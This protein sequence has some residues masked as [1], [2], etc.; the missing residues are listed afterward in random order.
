MLAQGLVNNPEQFQTQMCPVILRGGT[1]GDPGC[2]HAHH[3]TELRAGKSAKLG[4]IPRDW[5]TQFCESDKGVAYL[6]FICGMAM[7]LCACSNQQTVSL[8]EGRRSEVAN[9]LTY[10]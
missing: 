8:E 1:C 9:R 3:C 10:L 6:L 4:I 7:R 2:T 5:K